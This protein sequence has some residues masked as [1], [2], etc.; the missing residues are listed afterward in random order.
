MLQESND[1]RGACSGKQVRLRLGIAPRSHPAL[2]GHM[3]IHTRQPSR[4]P[5]HGHAT[6]CLGCP[7]ISLRRGGA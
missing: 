6:M 1:V 5:G 3:G 4:E 7:G 2:L